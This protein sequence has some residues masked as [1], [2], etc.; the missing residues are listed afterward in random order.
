LSKS[1]K[2]Q[3]LQAKFVIFVE[4]SFATAK[5]NK[6]YKKSVYGKG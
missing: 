5:E 2:I 6:I 4:L 1:I 3:I